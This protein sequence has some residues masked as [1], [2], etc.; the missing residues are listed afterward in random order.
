MNKLNEKLHNIIDNIYLF[1][2]KITDYEFIELNN[3][4]KELYILINDERFSTYIEDIDEY[5]Q[6]SDQNEELEEIIDYSTNLVY[7]QIFIIPTLC[8]CDSS[9]NYSSNNYCLYDCNNCFNL[10]LKHCHN[11]KKLILLHP[12]I[13]SIMFDNTS[14]IPNIEW[15]TEITKDDNIYDSKIY[16][17]SLNFL[18]KINNTLICRNKVF[19]L[20]LYNINLIFKYPYSY[21]KK[22]PNMIEPVKYK[23]RQL[24]SY[25]DII[26]SILSK[27]NKDFS[28]IEFWRQT[29]IEIEETIQYEEIRDNS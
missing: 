25:I 27:Y 23:I 9:N 28:I 4:I 17:S 11:F 2:H 15:N 5:E 13:E 14:T 12:V 20:I 1:K 21:F 22:Y 6:F 8:D 7:Y 19:F 3:L 16:F 24:Y 29:I 10:S 26:E 18:I